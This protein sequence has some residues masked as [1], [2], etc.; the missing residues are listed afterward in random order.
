[1]L[2]HQWFVGLVV[3]VTATLWQGTA[4]AQPGGGRGGGMGGPG[5]GTL[6]G[7]AGIPPV[8]KELGL[9][10]EAAEKLQKLAGAFRQEMQTAVEEAGIGFNAFGALQNL[11]QEERDAKMREMNDKR[12]EITKKLNDKFLPQLKEGLTAQQLARLQEIQTQFNGSQGLTSPEMIKALDLSKEQQEK[13]TAVNQDFG[14]KQRELFQPGG[15]GGAPDFQAMAAKREEL[16]KEREAKAAEVL[17]KEQQEKL[18][19]L[20]GKP[21][22]LSQL[23]PQGRRGGAGQ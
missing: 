1:M 10:G 7:L 23:Q 15:G 14:R 16:V 13:I 21:F 8:Q 5:G 3:V 22:D 17:S 9:E 11:S 4:N 19:K 12:T 6:I 18:A 20:K 2:R